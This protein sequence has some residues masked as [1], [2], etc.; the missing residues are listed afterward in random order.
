MRQPPAPSPPRARVIGAKAADCWTA[1]SVA[2]AISRAPAPPDRDHSK[3]HRFLPPFTWSY[4]SRD[5]RNRGAARL[6]LLGVASSRPEL[7][8]FRDDRRRAPQ[9]SPPMTRTRSTYLKDHFL[10]LHES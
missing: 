9:A 10:L 4:G 8:G 3:V 5:H 7:D 6:L 1:L 2:R